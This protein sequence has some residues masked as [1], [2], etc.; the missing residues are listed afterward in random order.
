LIGNVLEEDEIWSCT[1]C[2]ACEEECPVL[3]EYIDKIVDVR[4]GMV[5]DGRVPQSLQKPL[6]ALEKR[7]NPYGKTAKKRAD[8]IKDLPEDCNIKILEKEETADVLYFVDSITSYDD[9]IQEIGRATA[10][11]LLT[12]AIDFGILGPAEKDSGHEV[13]RFGEEML[14]QKLRDHNTDEIIKSGVQS[15]VTADPHAFNALK[16]D[17]QSLPPVEHVSQMIARAIK[18]GK[19]RLKEVEDNGVT[20]TYHDPCYLGRHNGLYDIPRDV[21]DAIPNLKRVE[22]SKCKDRS[23]CCGGGGLMLFYEPEEEIRMGNLRVKMA[24]QAGADVIVTACPFCLV[25]IEDAIKTSGLE[26]KMEAMDLVELIERHMVHD[27]RLNGST[28]KVPG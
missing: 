19:I 2:G 26:G 15:I 7:G 25:N 18:G 23:F 24:E 3:I 20:Y 5:D 17:Y 9:R 28:F 8:W 1:T 12:A 11:I 10:R 27:A 14:F 22:M 21:I 4:R 16:N 13:K 6:G